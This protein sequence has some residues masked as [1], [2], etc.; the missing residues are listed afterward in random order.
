MPRTLLPLLLVMLA[1]GLT[2]CGDTPATARDAGPGERG[3]EGAT[4]ATG[5]AGLVR[6]DTVTKPWVA[7]GAGSCCDKAGDG[8]T[9]DAATKA[10]AC[11]CKAGKAGTPVWCASCEKG[12]VDGK[13]VCC[14][15]CVQRAIDKA[16]AA[17]KNTQQ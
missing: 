16:A 5:P 10:A 7:E 4:P 8:T 1:L 6:D 13:E 17:A 12:Y 11:V 2:A 9:P 3:A 15:K 14:P